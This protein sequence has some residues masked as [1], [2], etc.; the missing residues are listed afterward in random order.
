MSYSSTGTS[1]SHKNGMD[2]EFVGS[3]PT[4]CVF[5]LP[6]KKE[7]E[8]KDICF[9]IVQELHILFLIQIGNLMHS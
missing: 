3:R 7:K 4:R 6:I 2:S 1:S 9:F 8:K 5:N